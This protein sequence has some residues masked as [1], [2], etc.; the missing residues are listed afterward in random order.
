MKI[1]TLQHGAPPAHRPRPH[2]LAQTCHGAHERRVQHGA[3]DGNITGKRLHDHIAIG[4]RLERGDALASFPIRNV[5]IKA[6]AFL[7]V[8]AFFF[9]RGNLTVELRYALAQLVGHLSHVVGAGE[10]HNLIEVNAKIT[11]HANQAHERNL[12]RRV[13][14]ITLLVHLGRSK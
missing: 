14:T 8:I 5:A 12:R 10:P 11:Q 3:V 13:K 6:Q 2:G 9:E 1:R 4:K 7:H